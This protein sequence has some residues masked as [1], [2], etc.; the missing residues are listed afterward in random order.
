MKRN[1]LYHL[2]NFNA[3]AV[4]IIDFFMENMSQLIKSK[5]KENPK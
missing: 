5:N 1:K 2:E 4:E 3:I